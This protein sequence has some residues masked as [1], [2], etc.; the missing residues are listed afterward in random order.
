MPLPGDAADRILRN[1]PIQVG[2]P[3]PNLSIFRTVGESLW[4]EQNIIVGFNAKASVEGDGIDLFVVVLHE[5]RP[6]D[7]TEFQGLDHFSR[8]Q[9]DSLLGLSS[10]RRV[11]AMQAE[12]LRNTLRDRY[13]RDGFPFCEIDIRIDEDDSILTFV[14]DEG[15]LI[16]VRD[17][18]FRGNRAFA[19]KLPLG[20]GGSGSL[21]RDSEI[22]SAPSWAFVK[23]GAYSVEIIEE[24]LDRLQLF[25]R[26]NGYRDA[27]VFLAAVVPVGDTERDLIFRVIEGERYRVTEVRLDHLDQESPPGRTEP[28]YPVEEIMAELGV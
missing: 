25:Y 10:D 12:S 11:T 1:F 19:G 13:R 9:V 3:L 7:R 28:S 17:V 8:A 5:D 26:R 21:V 24:D 20:I 15:P 18:H 27:E 22:Q 4:I 2:Q 16:T 6:Y 23:G 14:V